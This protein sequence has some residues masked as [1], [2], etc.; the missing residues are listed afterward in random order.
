MPRRP[1]LQGRRLRILARAFG[2]ALGALLFA[3]SAMAPPSVPVAAAA[4]ASPANCVLPEDGSEG[5]ID[6]DTWRRPIGVVRAVMLFVDFPDVPATRPADT[7]FEELGGPAASNWLAQSSYGKLSLQIEPLRHWLRMPEPLTAFTTINGS[8]DPDAA[9]RYI[10]EAVAL[11]D[12]EVDFSG[13]QVVQ[14]VPNPEAKG[15]PRSSAGIYNP[16]EGFLA[17]GHV[18]RAIVTFGSAVYGRGYRTL[19]HETSHA[20]GTRDLYNAY[21]SP[22]DKYVGAWSLMADTMR[23]GDHFAW[24]KWRMG[25]LTDS[26]VRCVTAAGRA[27]YVL[28]PLETTGGVKA[29]ILRTGLRTAIVAEYRTRRG[30]DAGVCSTGV[31]IYKVN[32]GLASGAGPIAVSDARRHTA[33]GRGSCPAELDDAAY[34]QGGRWTDST[35]GIQ[36]DVNAVGTGA[37]IQVIRTKTYVP[38]VR[39]ARSIT[40]NV[41]MNLDGTVTLN[42]V[43]AAP[44]ALAACA[45]SRKVSLQEWKAGEWWTIRTAN[46]DT[47]GLWT[48]TWQPD[49]G[50]TYRLLAPQRVTVADDCERTSSATFIAS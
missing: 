6:F 40:S 49:P 45:A 14:I 38:P 4:S 46:T 50:A 31:L 37:R 48:H 3:V 42:G 12:P 35:S 9:K 2:S 10:A 39:H 44:D 17:D 5:R 30:P 1:T 24:D 43:L 25:W 32:S 23:G 34:R 29:V 33:R 47:S 36:I 27:N 16:D 18:L 21:G 26:Q 41:A 8:L 11:A 22:T 13:V 20:F 15:Y 19:V 7:I 28:S